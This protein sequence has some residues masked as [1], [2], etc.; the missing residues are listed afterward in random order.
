MSRKRDYAIGIGSIAATLIVAAAVIYFWGYVQALQGYGYL[1]AFL[2]AVFGGATMLAPIP[3]TPVVLALGA[4]MKPAFAPHLGPVFVGAA[5]GL[6]DTLG[7][8]SIYLAGYGGAT[9]FAR[10]GQ[11]KL[12]AVY[13][14]LMRLM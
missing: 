4:V 10:G 12:Q 3:M 6:G 14:R 13:Q 2:V 9:P 7:G 1:G 8:L 5:A 11:H